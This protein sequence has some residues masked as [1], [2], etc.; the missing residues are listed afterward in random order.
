MPRPPQVADPHD[1]RRIALI[2]EFAVLFIAAPLLMRYAIFEHHVPL[3]YA[4]PPVLGLMIILLFT[5]TSFRLKR[6]L[7]RLFS[8]STFYSILILFA[9]GAAIVVY[10]M[11][12]LMPDRLFA[13][14]AER[15][16]KWAQI[17]VLYPFTSVLAQE[18]VYRVFFFHRYGPLFK[19]R[20]TL[21]AANALVFGFGH[22]IFR[23]WIAVGATVIGGALF[24]W[25]Y[26]R[27]RSFWAVWVEHVLWGWLV[28]TVGLGVFFFTG[29]ANPSW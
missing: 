24:A 15:P 1:G 29:V 23:N 12:K 19:S 8:F 17:M 2:V 10:A 20:W 25:R 9:I 26:E 27:S 6:E 5:D 21:I 28:F 22:I 16:G 18:L 7:M 3:F 4:L 11:A 14:A 13:L